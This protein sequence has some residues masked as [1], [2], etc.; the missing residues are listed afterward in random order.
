MIRLFFLFLFIPQVFFSKTEEP[1]LKKGFFYIFC[2]DVKKLELKASDIHILSDFEEYKEESKID[3]YLY[4]LSLSYCEWDKNENMEV[5]IAKKIKGKVMVAHFYQL[6]LSR[7]FNDLDT[8]EFYKLGVK[9]A[10]SK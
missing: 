2:V 8:V 9:Y 1:N 7:D 6:H 5:F 3:E 10:S 4:E